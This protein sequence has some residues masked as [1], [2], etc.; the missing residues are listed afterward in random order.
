MGVTKLVEAT[1]DMWYDIS[2]GYGF[3]VAFSIERGIFMAR[4]SRKQQ[5]WER[6]KSALSVTVGYIRLSVAN[7][8]ESSSIENQEFIIECWGDQHQIPISHY[9]IDNGFSG[10]RFDRPAFQEMIHDIIT[11]KVNCVVVK[12][13]SRL[14]RNHI[15]I[16]YYI[17]VLFPSNG[18]RFVSVNDHFDTIDGITNLIHSCSSRIRIPITNAFSQQVSIEIIKKLE[19]TLD[20]KAQNG[21]FIGPRAPFGYQKLESIPEQL[22]PDPNHLLSYEKS[23]R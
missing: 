10:K 11:G 16:G 13:L 4:K 15:T 7:K 3:A 9:Y 23:S 8:E 14:G 19:A 22:V 2:S 6:T 21:T 1:N 18:V 5:Y 17:E 20:M 12:D